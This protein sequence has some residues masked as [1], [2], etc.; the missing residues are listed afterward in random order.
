MA[1]TLSFNRQMCDLS[2]RSYKGTSGP[3]EYYQQ[4]WGM[5]EIVGH[6]WWSDSW[7]SCEEDYSGKARK[8]EDKLDL[9]LGVGGCL[10]FIMEFVVSTFCSYEEII[11]NS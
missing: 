1:H 6:I 11:K 3:S 4:R 9:I 10:C 2:V 5:Y 7:D 8:I